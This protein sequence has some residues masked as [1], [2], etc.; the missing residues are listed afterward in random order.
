MTKQLAPTLITSISKDE[1]LPFY[2]VR[3]AE[4]AY[5]NCHPQTWYAPSRLDSI[6]ETFLGTGGGFAQMKAFNT[7][8]PLQSRFLTPDDVGVV[9]THA[10]K[11]PVHGIMAVLGMNG[12][13]GGWAKTIPSFCVDCMKE[14]IALCGAPFWNRTN[15][16]PGLLLCSRHDRPLSSA[17]CENCITRYLHPDHNSRPGLHC[18]CGIA[19]LSGSTDLSSVRQ[20]QELELHR[21]TRKL[22]DPAYLGDL[23][24]DRLSD[25]IRARSVELGLFREKTMNH[26]RVQEFFNTHPWRPVLERVRIL[27]HVQSEPRYLTGKLVFRNPLQ[28]ITLT[29]ALFDNWSNAEK[30]IMAQPHSP[31]RESDSN[32]RPTTFCWKP[33]SRYAEL[34]IQRNKNRYFDIYSKKYSQILSDN[35]GITHREILNKIN[36]AK[37]ILNRQSLFDAGINVPFYKLSDD[38]YAQL[39]IDIAEH[40]LDKYD[41]LVSSD[42]QGKIGNFILLEDFGIGKYR[43]LTGH[44]PFTDAALKLCTA[45]KQSHTSLTR[46]TEDLDTSVRRNR[47]T[48]ANKVPVLVE[49][50]VQFAPPSSDAFESNSPN[51]VDAA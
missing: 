23:T 34:F 21:V 11:K 6:L 13:N 28:S 26:S 46:K 41:E 18:G 7:F 22:L 38:M 47:R 16:V 49:S 31:C 2:F 9:T 25:A 8:L 3:V 17:V 33:K 39:D 12:P 48:H 1:L 50:L 5:H 15:L 10:A 4:R 14:D 43:L 40:V 51:T 44:I 42:Y 19:P 35:I 37:N 30:S 20:E 36:C 27:A 24:R 45:L 29:H 32:S